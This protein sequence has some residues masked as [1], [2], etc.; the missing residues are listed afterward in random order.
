LG[1]QKIK[2]EIREKVVLYIKKR[3]VGSF[4]AIRE[5]MQLQGYGDI[6]FGL[7]TY[8]V[9]EYRKFSLL[10]ACLLFCRKQTPAQ[11]LIISPP[12]RK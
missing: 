9:E 5:F 4:K 11:Y 3:I 12:F 2:I 8:E 7:Y 6:C 10:R 1:I